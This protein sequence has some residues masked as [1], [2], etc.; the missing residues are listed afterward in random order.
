MSLCI[1]GIAAAPAGQRRPGTVLLAGALSLGCIASATGKTTFTFA[2]ELDAASADQAFEYVRDAIDT[3]GG[4]VMLDVAGL[5]FCD[6]RGL[7]ALAR[8]SSHAE[9]QGSSLHLVAPRP[10]LVKIIR[11]TGLGGKL[12][13]HRGDR[14]GQVALARRNHG[15]AGLRTA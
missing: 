10:L 7:G 4:D 5:N 14:V 6:A 2:G 13:I 11:I 8:M 15:I 12:P 3:Y 9:R 1:D